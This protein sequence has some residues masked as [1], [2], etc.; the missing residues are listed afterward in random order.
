MGDQHM[1]NQQVLKSTLPRAPERT[2]EDLKNQASGQALYLIP[3]ITQ[4]LNIDNTH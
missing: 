1:E 2:E 3:V 4:Y